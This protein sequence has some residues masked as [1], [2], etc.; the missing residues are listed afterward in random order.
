MNARTI[1]FLRQ[2]ACFTKTA[3]KLAGFN[4]SAG[5]W[6]K[7]TMTAYLCTCAVSQRVIENV[8]RVGKKL[9]QVEGAHDV[10]VDYED[11]EMDNGWMAAS[12]DTYPKIW[13][14]NVP[15]DAYL[16]CGIHLL[17]HGIVAYIVE[18]T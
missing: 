13:D 14:S 7:G 12:S 8:W 1:L 10:V 9:N 15:F 16:D 18:Q 4:V 11:G 17:F 5:H 6:N 3:V 2:D